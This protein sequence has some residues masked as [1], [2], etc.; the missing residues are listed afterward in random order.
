MPS[1][2]QQKNWK[3]RLIEKGMTRRRGV[4]RKRKR[5]VRRNNCVRRISQRRNPGAV[6][7][8]K[9]NTTLQKHRDR[10]TI[11]SRH[12]PGLLTPPAHQAD[13]SRPGTQSRARSDPRQNPEKL[14]QRNLNRGGLLGFE[15]SLKSEP[16][17]AACVKIQEGCLRQACRH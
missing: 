2:I 17:I 9:T 12:A 11:S 15:Q 7:I 13:R 8:R 16:E 4:K 6:G 1:P 10:R 14:F 3:R 5:N